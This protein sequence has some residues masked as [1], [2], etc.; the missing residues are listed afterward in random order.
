MDHAPGLW[1]DGNDDDICNDNNDDEDHDE[2][3][4]AGA[5]DGAPGGWH[6]GACLDGSLSS[7][8]LNGG[9]CPWVLRETGQC[10]LKPIHQS[11]RGI[12][13]LSVITLV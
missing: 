9:R 8:Q 6:D 3:G 4:H 12:Y 2:D 10:I 11:Y 13:I 7:K 5:A 1:Y